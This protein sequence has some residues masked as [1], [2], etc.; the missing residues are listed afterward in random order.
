MRFPSVQTL[1]SGKW[2]GQNERPGRVPKAGH[3]VAR[4]SDIY[5]VRKRY[6]VLCACDTGLPGGLCGRRTAK[7]NRQADSRRSPSLFQSDDKIFETAPWVCGKFACLWSAGACKAPA[8][9][10]LLEH[11]FACVL[12]SLG[13]TGVSRKDLQRGSKEI[14]FA[15]IQSAGTERPDGAAV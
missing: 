15:N 9:S 3:C 2:A 8:K 5:S 6:L 13:M 14:W 10:R 7:R 1:Q 11:P 4:R 12:G